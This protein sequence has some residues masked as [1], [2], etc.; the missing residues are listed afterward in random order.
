MNLLVREP[1]QPWREVTFEM[2]MFYGIDSMILPERYEGWQ[3]AEPVYV[4]TVAS[5]DWENYYEAD[6]ESSV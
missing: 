2:W 4:P 3:F 6:D 5:D 1:G